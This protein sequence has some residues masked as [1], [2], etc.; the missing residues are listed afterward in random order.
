MSFTFWINAGSPSKKTT[1][2]CVLFHS[3]C[4]RNAVK[5][6][7]WP[8]RVTIESLCKVLKVS[9]RYTCVRFSGI[10]GRISVH[11]LISAS[12]SVESAGG[13][14]GGI[15]VVSCAVPSFVEPVQ[16]DNNIMASIKTIYFFIYIV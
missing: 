7:S 14:G 11:T 12:S 5:D 3:W 16:A 6:L 2:N 15:C 9:I 1:F 13:G 4:L 8:L 10:G